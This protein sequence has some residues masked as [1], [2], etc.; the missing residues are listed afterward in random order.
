MI[1]ELQN[2]SVPPELRLGLQRAL[3]DKQVLAPQIINLC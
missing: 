2:N 1:K 3:A